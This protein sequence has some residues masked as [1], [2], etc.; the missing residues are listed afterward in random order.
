MNS[1][2]YVKTCVND[3]IVSS[4]NGVLFPLEFTFG[5]PNVVKVLWFG[6]DS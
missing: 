2:N 3:T 5:I 4:V 6:D 1:L